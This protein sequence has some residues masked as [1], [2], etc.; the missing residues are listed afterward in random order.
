MRL[1]S[2]EDDD[3]DDPDDGY[4]DGS[5]TDEIIDLVS[6]LPTRP[7]P[8]PSPA[9]HMHGPVPA[10]TRR[11]ASR[12]RYGPSLVAPPSRTTA[13]TS[14][15]SP[16]KRVQVPRWLF[17]VM[18]LY[19]A[20]SLY[21][22]HLAE[23]GPDNPANR[24]QRSIAPAGTAPKDTV[25][26]TVT[27]TVTVL[28]ES[29]VKAVALMQSIITDVSLLNSKANTQIDIAKAATR[30]IAE[31]DWQALREV[32]IQQR[33]LAQTQETAYQDFKTKYKPALDALAQ[34]EKDGK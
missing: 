12:P 33:D 22:M 16:D 4:P 15:R 10:A 8:G 21:A 11:P 27:K 19:I 32:Q 6:L 5:D 3:D 30:A 1:A 13:S 23:R 20:G 34:C 18:I 29:C 25:T 7:Y 14:P 17:W 31:K 28:P 9:R 24:E 26:V 2:Y